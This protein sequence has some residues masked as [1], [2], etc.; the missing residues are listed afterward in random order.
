[1]TTAEDVKR[2]LREYANDNH[3]GWTCAGASVRVGEIRDAQNEV[4][5]L[6]P[7]IPPEGTPPPPTQSA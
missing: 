3:P 7:V 4:L 1:M 6:L 5:L 2:V